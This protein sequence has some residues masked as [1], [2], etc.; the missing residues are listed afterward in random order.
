MGPARHPQ[1]EASGLCSRRELVAGVALGS[2]ALAMLDAPNAAATGQGDADQLRAIL[3]VELLVVFAYQQVFVSGKLGP[4]ADPAVRQMLDQ[5]QTHIDT[6]TGDL[7]KLGQQPP[8]GP[9]NLAAA[10][11]ELSVLHGSG[12]LASLRTEQ[13]CLS[14]LMGLEEIAQA[15]YYLALSKLTDPMLSKTAAAI[16]ATEGQHATVLSNLLH[17]GDIDKA[18]PGA[19]VEGRR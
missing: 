17:P 10:E 12:S 13:D 9:S 16:L 18:V 2:L 19:F 1:T 7:L 4:D 15:A 11:A 14:L 8:G 6:L 5:E 3:S